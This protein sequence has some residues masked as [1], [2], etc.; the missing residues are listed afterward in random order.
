[1]AVTVTQ[2]ESVET[3]YLTDTYLETS[4]QLD[5][6]GGEGQASAKIHKN[7]LQMICSDQLVIQGVQRNKIQ[8][9]SKSLEG[10]PC[11][12]RMVKG[13]TADCIGLSLTLPISKLYLA[14]FTVYCVSSHFLKSRGWPLYAG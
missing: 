8:K 12:S 13:K 3:T 11:K 10:C 7:S 5:R 2:N 14:T 1:M 9:S 6:A 4:N